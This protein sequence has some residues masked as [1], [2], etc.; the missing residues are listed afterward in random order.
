VGGTYIKT[1]IMDIIY[2]S[3]GNK[4]LAQIAIEEGFLYGARSDD[5]RDIRCNG[6]IDI[7]WTNY[8]WDKHLKQVSLHQPKY[9]VA[10][11]I[12]NENQIDNLL[13]MAEQLEKFCEKVIIVPKIDGIVKSIPLRFVIGISVPTSYSGFLPNIKE[14]RD[15]N[16]HLLGGS[17]G[18]QRDLWRYYSR[19]HVNIMSVD[20]NCHSKASDFGSYW[21]G[22]K[23]CDKERDNIGKYEA[24]RKSCRGI[25]RMW[26][27][28]GVQLSTLPSYKL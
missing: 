22:S 23:W 28:L 19:M 26:N 2:C 21:N 11:D 18:Q 27:N 16:T 24:F 17:P 14:L 25:L 4:K 9:A 3:G 20:T 6:L 15:R 10:P 13:P 1:G 7:N 5:I 12:T 8:N